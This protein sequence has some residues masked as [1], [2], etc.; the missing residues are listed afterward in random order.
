M[1]QNVRVD[2]DA[3]PL[4]RDDGGGAVP[5][6]PHSAATGSSTYEGLAGEWATVSTGAPSSG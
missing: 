3:R 2:D 4:A 1:C 6:H 5:T